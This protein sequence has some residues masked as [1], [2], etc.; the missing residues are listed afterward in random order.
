M[1]QAMRSTAK[2]I[3]VFIII[4]FVGGFLIYESAGLFGG[5]PITPATTV[6]TVNGDEILYGQW[7]RAIQ[8]IETQQIQSSGI[9]PSLDERREIEQ[10]ALDQI[11]EEIL[12]AQEIKRRKITVTPEEIIQATRFNPPQELMQSPELQTDGQFDYEK[13]LRFLNGPTAKQSGLLWQL[14]AYYKDQIP[15]QKLYEQIAAASYP[16]DSQLWRNY[17]D[18]NDSAQVSFVAFRPQGADASITIPDSELRD[19]YNKHK[20]RFDRPGVA[21]VTYTRIPRVISASDSLAVRERI[22]EIKQRIAAGESFEDIARAESIDSISARQGGDLGEGPAGRFVAPFEEA[23]QKLSP[24]EL[25]GPVLTQFGYHLIKMESRDG[26]N[27]HLKHILLPIT[28]SD[29]EASITD[30]K[31]DSLARIAAGSDDRTRFDSATS[32]LKLETVKAF[33]REGEPLVEDDMLIPS[34]SAWAFGGAKVGSTSDLF[35]SED[36]Y[37]LA[38]LESLTPGGPAPFESVKEEIRAELVLQKKLDQLVD[39]AKSFAREAAAT[40]LEEAAGKENLTVSETISFNRVSMVP[41]LGRANA[42]VG[43]AFG[44]PVGT[45]SAPIKTDDGVYVIR[46]N[47]RKEADRDAFEAEKAFLRQQA[48]PALQQAHVQ[49][50]LANL[51]ESAKIKDERKKIQSSIAQFSE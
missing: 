14:E 49:T 45:I 50:F 2:Y 15:K 13:Y 20:D 36:G 33:V 32:L 38:R 47:E 51:R 28:Q 9:S 27:L 5:A 37:F 4:A 3:W 41:G 48:V 23:A 24:G 22:Q 40:S 12:L 21:A 39:K 8:Q 10:L 31:A 18:Q 42:A 46:V 1:L 34:V 43:A 19:F 35:D 44:L 16:S 6:A 29:S 17:Q 11:I 25:S 7:Q 30:R 26:D